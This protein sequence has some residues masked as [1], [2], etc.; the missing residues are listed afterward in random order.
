MD[1]TG[2][3]LDVV[4]PVFNEAATLRASILTLQAAL[5]ASFE[6]IGWQITIADNA[7]TDES[8]WIA[9]TLAKTVPGVRVI[10]LT[11]KGR[12]R[13]LKTAW[14][15]S[16]AEV[17]AYM[18][19]DLSTDLR[20]LAP[21]VAPLL[22]GHSDVAI[23]SRLA[24]GARVVRG[25]RRELL[26]RGYNALLRTA[27][28]VTFSDAQCGFKAMTA[29]AARELLPHVEDTGW[30]FDTELLVLAERIGLRIT[31]VP[32]DW[33]DDPS[34]SVDVGA[35]VRGDLAGI[36]RLER[37]LARGRVPLAELNTKLGRRPLDTRVPLMLQIVRFGVI[38]VGAT[39][40]Y[41]LLYLALQVI[42]PAQW[43]NF[44][45]LVISAVVNTAVNRRV[46]FGVRD[47]S[48]VA[49]HLTEGLVVFGVTWAFTSTALAVAGTLDP[50][51]GPWRNL[52]VL[53]TANV[54]ATVAKFV[55]FHLL[56]RPTPPA[57]GAGA[58]HVTRQEL[59]K[60]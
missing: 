34:S 30:F 46:T 6:T 12:G 43:S 49:L 37:S 51:A 11:E 7:S 27:L 28:G 14:L 9:D 29:R 59:L 56:F 55:A 20:A 23:G 17:V 36:V 8:G 33:L 40:L 45:A 16:D 18:D 4:V 35:T 5:R 21:L 47:R 26:S 58:E 32:V 54:I 19:V 38:G 22:S 3:R 57:E 39:I 48:T 53:T 52:V 2:P 50:N 41:S 44:V 1:T 42:M 15:T 60:V 10:H 24:R 13:A 31:E 25:P